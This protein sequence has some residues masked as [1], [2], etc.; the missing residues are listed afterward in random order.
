GLERDPPGRPQRAE[1]ADLHR[2][3]RPGA[4]HPR[5]HRQLPGQHGEAGP[6]GR[7]GGLPCGPA[8]RAG[9]AQEGH[10]VRLLP[11]RLRRQR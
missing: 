9:Q 5:A 7:R 11:L 2:Q 1:R 6:G 10:P 8:G 4:A 3:V